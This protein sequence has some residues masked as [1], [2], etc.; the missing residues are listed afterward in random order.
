MQQFRRNAGYRQKP[1]DNCEDWQCGAPWGQVAKRRV[2]RLVALK[3][4]G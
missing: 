2:R 4:V 3:F 1:E